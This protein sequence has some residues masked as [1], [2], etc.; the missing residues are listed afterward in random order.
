[1]K[2][3]VVHVS[4]ASMIVTA[5]L[6]V[7]AGIVVVARAGGRR[8]VRVGLLWRFVVAGWTAATWYCRR[9]L[10]RVTVLV[11]VAGMVV[12]AVATFLVAT[13]W[14]SSVYEG[15]VDRV[16]EQSLGAPVACPNGTEGRCYTSHD[17]VV[18][19]VRKGFD[20]HLRRVSP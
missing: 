14:S 2:E 12:A 7:L 3:V 20:V 13:S 1:M 5:C 16:L 15:E 4:P 11:G 18:V 19:A 10:G 6:A 9:L 17:Q 8:V